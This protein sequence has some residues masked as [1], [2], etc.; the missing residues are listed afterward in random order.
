M[1]VL[2]TQC[3]GSGI[4]CFSTL[5]IRDEFFPDPGSFLLLLRLKLCSWQHKKQETLSV[6]STFHVESGIWD[7]NMF[8]SGIRDEN[9]VGSGIKHPKSATVCVCSGTWCL[10]RPRWSWDGCHSWTWHSPHCPA[11][12]RVRACCWSGHHQS[13]TGS[14]QP[15][16]LSLI[17]TPTQFLATC[18]EPK[19]TFS[20]KLYAGLWIRIRIQWLC[21]SGSVLGI[22]VEKCT[23]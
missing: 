9:M 11:A 16:H 8:G 12:V 13:R 18:Y 3:C 19:K 2:C 14:A 23:F 22:S 20:C 10:S 5:W 21:G 17:T 1:N 15:T 6:H 7:E 4:R